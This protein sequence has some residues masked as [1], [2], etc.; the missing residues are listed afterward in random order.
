MFH[1]S[2][3]SILL[4]GNR[5]FYCTYDLQSGACT[6]SP[7]GLWGSNS[8]NPDG[9]DLS[10][11]TCA[12]SPNGD[13]LAVAGRRGYVHLVD[14]RRGGGQVVGSVKMNNPVKDLHWAADNRLLSLGADCEIF[15]WD[16]DNYRCLRRWKDDGGFGSAIMTGSRN[17]NHLAIGWVSLSVYCSN[18][19]N[20]TLF[21]SATTGLVNLYGTDG[22][23]E[24]GSSAPKPLKTVENL[25]TAISSMCFNHDAQILAISSHTKKDQLKLVSLLLFF[26]LYCC[27]IYI[28]RLIDPLC[29]PGSFTFQY[30]IFQLADFENTLGSCYLDGFFSQK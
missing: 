28:T 5:P 24:V 14:W 9:A 22:F 23:A 1:P 4:T 3:S 27:E 2:G 20:M 13:Y 8:G 21:H 12:F 10:M 19:K 30:S 16:I 29:I 15:L 6:Q 25:T 7:R 26:S 11:E 17:Q 18:K